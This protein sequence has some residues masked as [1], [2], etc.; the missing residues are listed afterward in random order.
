MQPRTKRR[1]LLGGLAVAGLGGAGY[2]LRPDTRQRRGRYLHPTTD[3]TDSDTFAYVSGI[4]HDG[5]TMEVQVAMRR[6]S[7]DER[8]ITLFADSADPVE[9]TMAS[10]W[11]FWRFDVATLGIEPGSYVLDVAGDRLAV[12]VDR[13]IPAERRDPRLRL[14]PRALWQSSSVAHAHAMDTGP[15]TGRMDVSFRQRSGTGSDPLERLELRTPTGETIASHSVPAG[16][17]ETSFDVDPF[18]SF[19]GDA[20]LLGFRDEQVVDDVELFYH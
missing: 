9:A 3:L 6:T 5:T 20:H 1:T 13:R 2:L 10:L 15:E 17:Y 14:T 11:G 16:V 18:I 12:T 19:E 8:A 4:A 7:P